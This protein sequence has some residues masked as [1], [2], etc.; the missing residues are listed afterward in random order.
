MKS[1]RAILVFVVFLLGVMNL[2]ASGPIGIYGIIE[3]VIFEPNEQAPQRIQL[4]GA[5]EYV[6]GGIRGTGATTAPQRGYLYFS[7]PTGA[8]QAAAKAEWVDLK[9]VAGTGQA[10]GFG[11]WGYVGPFNNAG[12]Q[13]S[14][15]IRP[16]SE[17]PAGPEGYF[18]NAGI[19]KLSEQGSHAQIVKQLQDA[20][21][22]R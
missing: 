19:V 18:T 10:V 14:A 9:A 16:Q 6:D 5:F 8:A 3:R 1:T 2:T 13:T 4:W 7:L 21:R 22:T 17:P 12:M 11:N 15:R 20:L